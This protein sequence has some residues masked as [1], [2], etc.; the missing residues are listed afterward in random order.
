MERQLAEES[1]HEVRGH[2]RGV[3]AAVLVVQHVTPWPAVKQSSLILAKLLELL[4][5]GFIICKM[6]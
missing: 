5:L 2:M 1:E 4:N 3:Q 6:G